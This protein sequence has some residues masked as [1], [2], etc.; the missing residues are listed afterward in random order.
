L[1]CG[2]QKYNVNGNTS[3]VTGK[4]S[5][6]AATR[7]ETEKEIQRRMKMHEAFQFL[8]KRREKTRQNMS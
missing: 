7:L 1:P 8:V 6:S 2:V 4:S 3:T 5:S